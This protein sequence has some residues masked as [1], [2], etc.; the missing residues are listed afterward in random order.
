M[1]P[2]EIKVCNVCCGYGK[3][4]IDNT[5]QECP[6]CHGLGY[7]EDL[8]IKDEIEKTIALLD[9]IIPKEKSEIES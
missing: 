6:D 7:F 1:T 9:K 4:I 8:F 2:I 5:L 3:R